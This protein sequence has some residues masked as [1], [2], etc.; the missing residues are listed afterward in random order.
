[1]VPDRGAVGDQFPGAP[2]TRL[3]TPAR[4]GTAPKLGRR[5]WRRLRALAGNAAVLFGMIRLS[6]RPQGETGAVSGIHAGIGADVGHLMSPFHAVLICRTASLGMVWAGTDIAG[7]FAASRL[8]G[9]GYGRD[10]PARSAD[11]VAYRLVPRERDWR[12]VKSSKSREANMVWTGR[13][14][15]IRTGFGDP[16]ST[17]L[18]LR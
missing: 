16:D 11:V 6:V 5:P 3:Q 18:S 8:L 2:P 4:I 14:K 1:V 17:F 13:A 15:A 9:A 7:S 12:T 10:L